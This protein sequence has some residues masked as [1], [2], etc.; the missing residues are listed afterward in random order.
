[1]SLRIEDAFDWNWWEKC[2]GRPVAVNAMRPLGI[3][4][5]TNGKLYA[6]ARASQ[7]NLS[8]DLFLSPTLSSPDPVTALRTYLSSLPTATAIHRAMRILKRLLLLYTARSI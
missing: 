6:P 1:M 2:G 7:T 3:D 5:T 8:T 4:V